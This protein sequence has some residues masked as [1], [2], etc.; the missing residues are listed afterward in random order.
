MSVNVV[1]LRKINSLVSELLEESSS[2]KAAA[3][4]EAVSCDRIRN[5]KQAIKQLQKLVLE[6][7][8][9]DAIRHQKVTNLFCE[10]EK[11][12]TAL[13]SKSDDHKLE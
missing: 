3:R 1:N 5:E 9:Q 12:Q 7:F 2:A 6:F 11:M 8:E 4:I 13:K 10:I